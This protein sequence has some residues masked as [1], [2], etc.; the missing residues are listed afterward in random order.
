MVSSA[1]FGPLPEAAL[2]K[3]AV[4]TTAI[5]QFE[6]SLKNLSLAGSSITLDPRKP[7]SGRSKAEPTI[8]EIFALATAGVPDEEW[9]K[10]PTDLSAN[11]HHYRNG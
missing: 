10:L 7:T 11:W 9:K 6:Q 1:G 4:T 3:S 5:L 8:V 2:P